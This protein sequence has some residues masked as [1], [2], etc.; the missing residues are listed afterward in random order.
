MGEDSL[1][2]E[3]LLGMVVAAVDAVKAVGLVEAVGAAGA[4][5]FVAVVEM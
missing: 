3:V 1:W 5:E 2:A 4:V